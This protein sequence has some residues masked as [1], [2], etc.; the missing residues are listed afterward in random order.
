MIE[1]MFSQ[2]DNNDIKTKLG[3]RISR[4]S[5]PYLVLDLIKTRKADNCLIEE[6]NLVEA[7]KLSDTIT[8]NSQLSTIKQI[9]NLLSKKYTIHFTIHFTIYFTI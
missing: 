2:W 4:L 9:E 7:K 1:S 8:I 6:E 5:D 3:N